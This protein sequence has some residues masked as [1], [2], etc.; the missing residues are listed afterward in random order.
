MA[1]R[2]DSGNVG[3]DQLWMETLTPE[4][5]PYFDSTYPRKAV[6]SCIIVGTPPNTTE[7]KA[8][9]FP[10]DAV[11]ALLFAVAAS[12]ASLDVSKDKSPEKELVRVEVAGILPRKLT[13]ETNGGTL[14]AANAIDEAS[15][16]TVELEKI[17]DPS[18]ESRRA[19]LYKAI[20]R[21]FGLDQVRVM[22]LEDKLGEKDF[23][24]DIR[25]SLRL[26]EHDMGSY[27]DIFTDG[28]KKA[29]KVVMKQALLNL[30]PSWIKAG[31]PDAV[32]DRL[33]KY[34]LLEMLMII[35]KIS[36]RV[37]LFHY[38]REKGYV[39]LSE[40]YMRRAF[41]TDE[42]TD[43][44]RFVHMDERIDGLRL[45]RNENLAETPRERSSLMHLSSSALEAKM[46]RKMR[47]PSYRIQP[48]ADFERGRVILY[49]TP[50]DAQI[51]KEK[52]ADTDVP[53]FIRFRYL[54]EM[55]LETLRLLNAVE[56]PRTYSRNQIE[57]AFGKDSDILKPNKDL[58]ILSGHVDRIIEVFNDVVMSQFARELANPTGTF[59]RE[60]LVS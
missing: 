47:C 46:R 60:G 27:L 48:G 43:V 10:V 31:Q 2:E 38:P 56:G 52:L 18:I 3:G 33:V 42:V 6:G 24:L 17:A 32:L 58:S 50:D 8:E 4:L 7:G 57:K 12:R 51:I 28:R 59:P 20:A 53:D 34:A 14:A 37:L 15:N 39:P 44:R 19:D 35:R 11:R 25:S 23:E 49:P 5:K 21:I 40:A 41:G 16:P 30:I 29:S 55:L 1:S 45:V 26:A 54:N 36:K 13:E 9:Q 22:T